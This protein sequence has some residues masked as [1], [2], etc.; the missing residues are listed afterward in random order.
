MDW[1]TLLLLKVNSTG[2]VTGEEYAS[3]QYMESRDS[4]TNNK[5]RLGCECI[6]SVTDCET[7][8][9]V[10]ILKLPLDAFDVK[11]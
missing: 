4:L 9:T 10:F 5:E 3:L 6:R 7:F 11:R 8:N 1:K 2:V